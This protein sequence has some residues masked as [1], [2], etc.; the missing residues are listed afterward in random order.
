MY[1][2]AQYVVRT[3]ILDRIPRTPLLRKRQIGGCLL[4]PGSTLP[5]SHLC[6]HA[7]AHLSSLR[8]RITHTRTKRV[9]ICRADPRY[10]H[11]KLRKV[12]YSYILHRYL[13][14]DQNLLRTQLCR[15][16]GC[17]EMDASGDTSDP[18]AYDNNICTGIIPSQTQLHCTYV[19]ASFSPPSPSFSSSRNLIPF[20]IKTASLGYTY[21]SMYNRMY[22]FCLTRRHNDICRYMTGHIICRSSSLSNVLTYIEISL[23]HKTDYKTRS[24]RRQQGRRAE[25]GGCSPGRNALQPH[26][27]IHTHTEDISMEFLFPRT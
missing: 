7:K 8:L 19:F 3:Y 12:N 25:V 15:I 14:T 27:S 13:K 1:V 17:A 2:P 4:S 9:Q 6:I 21:L 16:I 18:A 11:M 20:C 24:L 26:M 5:P 22:A 23:C 10:V